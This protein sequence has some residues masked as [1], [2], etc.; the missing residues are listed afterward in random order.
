MRC[1]P[2][3]QV[4]WLRAENLMP[5]DLSCAFVYLLTV[6]EQSRQSGAICES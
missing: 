3:T 2:G 4:K 6:A 1:T 5:L